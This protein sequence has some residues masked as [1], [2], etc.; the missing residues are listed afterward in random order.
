MV[1]IR[2]LEE[3]DAERCS[4]LANKGFWDEIER[5]M[6]EFTPEYFTSRLDS[7]RVKMWV[8]E[9]DEV[10]GFV[11]ITEANVEVPA[12]LHLITVDETKR[13]QGIGKQ[14]VQQIMDYVVENKWSKLKLSTRPWNNAMRKVC[15]DLGFIQE[16]YLTKEYLNKDLIQ[17]GYF[18]EY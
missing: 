8:A 7:Q 4:L 13:K 3:K 5:G 11:L 16:A 12:M 1:E 10:L 9:E 18:P 14:L 6:Q 2:R 15:T 17:Y